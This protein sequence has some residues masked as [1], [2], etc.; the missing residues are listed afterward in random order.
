MPIDCVFF[1]WDDWEIIGQSVRLQW[2]PPEND[3]GKPVRAYI[4]ER[5]D[6]QRTAWLKEARCKTTTYEIESLPLG[7][8]HIVRV[9]AE[10]EEGLS[11]PC[12]IDRPIQID[13]KD[14]KTFSSN[15]SNLYFH[16]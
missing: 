13:A 7:A 4:I 10:N 11:A 1:W 8:Q 5:R 15:Y 6:M 14:R 3:G 2:D 12:E 9:T 16:R